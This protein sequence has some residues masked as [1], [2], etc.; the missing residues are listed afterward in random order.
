MALSKLG[1][2][3]FLAPHRLF[4]QHNAE[5][6]GSIVVQFYPYNDV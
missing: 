1:L 4:H 2:R 6:S 5:G 3:L